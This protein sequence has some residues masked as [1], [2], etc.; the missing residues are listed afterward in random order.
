MTVTCGPTVYI[1]NLENK[2]VYTDAIPSEGSAIDL[3]GYR[4]SSPSTEV[5]LGEYG[6]SPLLTQ[7]LFA[8][9][10]TLVIGMTGSLESPLIIVI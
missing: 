10:W 5:A 9:L 4:E 1:D 7:P 3:E 8:T 6:D 2:E